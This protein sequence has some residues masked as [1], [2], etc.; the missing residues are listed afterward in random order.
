MLEPLEIFSE[1][2]FFE[3]NSGHSSSLSSKED[4]IQCHYCNFKSNKESEVER[5]SVISHPGKIA[6][7][8]PSLLKLMK[9]IEV[10]STE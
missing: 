6:R 2:T 3:G 5:H 8:D 1:V 10:K 4:S 7:P 9:E